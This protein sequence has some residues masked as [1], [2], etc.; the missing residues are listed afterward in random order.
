MKKIAIGCGV[1]SSLLFV[2]AGGVGVYWVYSKAKDYVGSFKQLAEVTELD[3]QVSNTARVH[4]SGE[5]GADRRPGRAVRQGERTGAGHARPAL[6][7]IEG[8][9][10]RDGRPDEGRRPRRQSRRGLAA[11]KD[12]GPMVKDVRTAQVAALNAQGM[13]VAEYRWVRDETFAAAGI[14]IAGFNLNAFVEAARAA[15]SR[16]S[17]GAWSTRSPTPWNPTRRTRNS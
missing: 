10:R 6:P 2:V 9:L 7:A 14:P 16:R 3:R 1:G 13:S 11:L 12:L 5:R 17:R 8:A 15:T 4:T